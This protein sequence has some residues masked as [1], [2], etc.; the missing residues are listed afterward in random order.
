MGGQIREESCCNLVCVLAAWRASGPKRGAGA[1]CCQREGSVGCW[2]DLARA[3]GEE[4]RALAAAVRPAAPH[5]FE[6][7]GD[8]KEKRGASAPLA[9]AVGRP[10]RVWEKG[11]GCN[12]CAGAGTGCSRDRLGFVEE[13]RG[14]GTNKG[15]R[16]RIKG[17]MGG[18][19]TGGAQPQ[20]LL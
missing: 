6:V 19:I 13:S 4:Y 12:R 20:V 9:A 11:S 5:S 18:Q 3:G 16:G 8:L 1:L 14:Q 7:W 15:D 17:Q 2:A 10:S